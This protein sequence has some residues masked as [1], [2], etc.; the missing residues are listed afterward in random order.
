LRFPWYL[1][2]RLGEYLGGRWVLRLIWQR[3]LGAL[4]R[5]VESSGDGELR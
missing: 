3:N 2:G 1:G 4:Q 5:V